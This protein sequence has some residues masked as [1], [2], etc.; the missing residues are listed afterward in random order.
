MMLTQGTVTH[1]C[2]LHT[3]HPMPTRCLHTAVCKLC[4]PRVVQAP[5]HFV[6]FS[7]TN[8]TRNLAAHFAT[9]MPHRCNTDGTQTTYTMVTL[10]L[11]NVCRLHEAHTRGRVRLVYTRCGKSTRWRCVML[12]CVC[13]CLALSVPLLVPYTQPCVRLCKATHRLHI[14]TP[15]THYMYA[16]HRLHTPVQGCV[17]I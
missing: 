1:K 6:P 15:L 10:P 16:T 13:K 4:V 7:Y 14:R 17:I 3:S 9:H 12:L 11:H 8:I 2:G 5:G